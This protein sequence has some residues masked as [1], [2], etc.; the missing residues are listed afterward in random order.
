[1]HCCLYRIF[2]RAVSAAACWV[3]VD[4]EGGGVTE[5]EVGGM[6]S[7]K[8]GGTVVVEEDEVDGDS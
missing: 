5:V 8:S 6:M 1:M 7:E 3:A 2:N 4:K